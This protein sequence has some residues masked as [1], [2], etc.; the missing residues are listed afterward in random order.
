[1][2][3]RASGLFRMCAE[4]GIEWE[5]VTDTQK[6]DSALFGASTLNLAP[7]IIKDDQMTLSQSVACHTYLGGKLGFDKGIPLPELAL[8]Y[9]LDLDDLERNPSSI[10]V[11]GNHTG[12]S[13]HM[14]RLSKNTLFHQQQQQQ[15]HGSF[16]LD[17][18]KMTGNANF[19]YVLST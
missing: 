13:G 19:F 4:A 9:I 18:I 11:S 5:L 1:M 8:Q 14:A 3:A 12:S 2:L 10:A 17:T 6:E 16:S 7:P 15:Q